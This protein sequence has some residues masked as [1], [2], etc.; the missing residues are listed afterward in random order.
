MESEVLAVKPLFK[1]QNKTKRQKNKTK[2]MKQKKKGKKRKEKKERK[3]KNIPLIL[4][5]K[6]R[7]INQYLEFLL[8][9][10]THGPGK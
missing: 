5:Q 7:V 4:L 3:N 2:G 9:M 1:E 10:E 8:N 6:R